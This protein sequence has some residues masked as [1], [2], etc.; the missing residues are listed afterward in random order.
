MIKIRKANHNDLISLQEIKP[1]FTTE[2]FLSRLADQS[3]NRIEFLILFSDKLPVCF[4]TLSLIGKL[5]HPEY[6]D[7]SDLYTK[8]SRRREGFAT[9]LIKYCEYR[10]KKLG[11]SKLGLAVN[12]TEN[13]RAISIYESLG[14]RKTGEPL[15]LDGIYNG[16]EDWVIDMEKNL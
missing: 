6:C 8:E 14:F 15:Y 4:V 2:V 3:Q 5:T 9:R 7:L 11:S 12:P 10:A 13:F 16:V 1:D